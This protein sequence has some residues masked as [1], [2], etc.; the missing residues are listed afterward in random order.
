V[1][2][3]VYGAGGTGVTSGLFFPSGTNGAFSSS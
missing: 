1:L 3:I 2:N